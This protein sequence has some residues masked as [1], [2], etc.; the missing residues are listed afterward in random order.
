MTSSPL[1]SSPSIVSLPLDGE[2]RLSRPVTG[3]TYAALVPGCVHTDL[4]RAGVLAPMD[5]RDNEATQQWIDAEEWVYRRTFTVDETF[6]A[7]PVE[8]VCDGLDTLASVSINGRPALEANNMF[9]TWRRSVEELLITGENTIEVTFHSTLPLL[10]EGQKLRPLREWNIYFD[11]HAGRGYIR[12]MACSYGWDWGPVAPTAGIWKNIRLESITGAR[13]QDVALRQRHSPGQATLYVSWKTEGVGTVTL[14][15]WIDNTLVTQLNSPSESGQ[16]SLVVDHPQLW[17]PNDLGAQPLY[18]FRATLTDS[19][20]R[21]D[22]WHRRIG[23][24]ALRLVRE[25]DEAGESFTF[26]VNGTAIFAKGANWVPHRILLPEITREDYARLLGDAADSHMNMLRVWGGGIYEDDAFYEICD[27][28]GILVWQDFQFA[29]G[30]YPTWDAKFLANV[31]QEARDNVR[32]LRHHASLALWCGNNE[33]EGAF[34][35]QPFYSWEEYGALFD[36]VLPRVC[37]ELDPDHVYWPSSPHSPKG[38]RMKT[39]SDGSGDTHHW[40]VFFG[41]QSIESQR[42]W[43]CRFMSEYGF[44]SFPELKTIESFTE[45]EDR[46]LMS[47]IVDYRQRSEV[48]NQTIFSYLI[49]WFQVPSD[50]GDTLTLSQLTHSLCVR[51]AAEHLRRLQPHCGGVLYWQINDIWPCASWSSIDAFGRWKSL[52]YEAKRFFAPVLISIEEDLLTSRARVHLSNQRADEAT[53]LCHWQITNTDGKILWEDQKE[54]TLGAQSGKYL[55]DIDATPLLRDHHAHDLMIWAWASQ[56]GAIVS[57]NWAPLA[58]PKHLTLADPQLKLEV[59]GAQIRISSEKP[60]PYVRLSASGEDVW[61]DDNFF[62]LHPNEPRVITVTRG[63]AED[64]ANRLSAQS[65]ADWMPARAAD[66]LLA[67]KD[68]GYQLQRKR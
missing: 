67:L 55:G 44:Q 15:L 39:D 63:S 56:D 30:M 16:A 17:W 11:R 40:S 21:V 47:R 28:L 59:D 50:F 46:T 14:E 57:R 68:A 60:A 34:A 41:R 66:S 23:L 49:D 9:R 52:Q 3:D 38:D 6:L 36:E 45:P 13:W 18:E 65:L 22:T 5:W 10:A 62:H 54:S 48:G 24:R 12:K 64:L 4:A 2:W 29:C 35:G 61:F 26:E 7:S 43:R 53:F 58:R 31:E 33:M 32:R 51:Y 20:G 19:A 1:L 42:N 25:P 37:A 8:L 27:E